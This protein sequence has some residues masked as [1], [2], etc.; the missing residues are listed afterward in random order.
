MAEPLAVTVVVPTRN[1][2]PLASLTALPSVLGQED[3]VLELVVVDDGSSDETPARLADLAARDSRVHVLRN[4]T[5]QGVAAA[6]NRG[7]AAASAPWI[8]FLDDDD[9]WSP[10]KLAAQLEAAERDGATWVFSGAIAMTSAGEPLYEYYFPDPA[11]VREQLRR[12]AVVP[13]GASNVM[14]RTSLLRDLGGFDEHL[15]MLADWDMWIRLSEAGTPAVVREVH[16]AV[17]HHSSSGHAVTD[18]SRE[19]EALVRKHAARTPAV[20]VDPDVLGHGRWVASE[21]SRVG[22]RRQAAWLYARDAWRHRSPT[23]VLRAVDALLGKQ[24]SARTVRRGSRATRDVPVVAPVWLARTPY[25][26][27][28]G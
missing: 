2:W 5:S 4:D 16:V 11:I 3:V 6:R 1:R 12:S 10:R 27:D 21:H 25:V 17:L 15:S 8:A 24:L 18:Q 26:R 28:R 14:S 19:L 22:R 13:A 7:I 20:E 9:V 23:N